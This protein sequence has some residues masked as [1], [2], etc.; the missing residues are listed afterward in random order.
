LQ[1]ARQGLRIGLRIHRSQQVIERIVTRHFESAVLRGLRAPPRSTIAP[2]LIA[3]SSR[4]H[5]FPRAPS[6]N[7]LKDLA[8]N[9]FTTF[10][11]AS[12]Q[13]L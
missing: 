1:P 9:P 2:L 12:E 8:K 13:T 4:A 11:T 3:G 7:S 10:F 5:I 6:T